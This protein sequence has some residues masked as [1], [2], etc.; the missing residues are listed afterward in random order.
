MKKPFRAYSGDQPYIF[1]SYAHE[2]SSAVYP[3]MKWLQDQGFN[4]WY[5]EGISPGTVWRT[6]LADSIMGAGLF[7]FFVTPRSVISSNCEKEVNFAI[8]HDIPVL[9]VHLEETVLPSGMELTLSSIQGIL[10]FDLSEQDYREKLL[11]STSKHL[12]RGIGSA[13]A[14]SSNQNRKIAIAISAVLG[15]LL[16]GYLAI[17][18][19]PSD[20]P[21]NALREASSLRRFTI[22]LPRSMQL[23]NILFR[24]VIIS[25]DGQRVIFS[26]AEKREAQLYSR[27]LD[28]LDVVPIK[29]TENASRVLALSPDN[30]WIAF[31]DRSTSMLIKVPVTG[32]IPIPLC[33]LDGNVWGLSWGAND[34]IL[35]TSGTSDGLMQVS[36]SGGTPEQLTF[37]ENGEVHKQAAFL[38]DASA[39]FFTIGEKGSTIRKADRIAVLSLE[40]GEQKTLMAGASPQATPNGHLIYYVNNALWAV[41]FDAD[42]LEVKGQSVPVADGVLYADS[43]HYSMSD[44][45]T[46]VYVLD[47]GLEKRSLV[48]V[49]RFGNEEVIPIDPRHYLTA[50]ISP[51]GDR[52]A[53]T[54]KTENGFDL[55]MY[56][57][58]RGTSRQLTFDESYESGMAWSPD[59]QYIYYSSNRI[60]NI[61]RVSTDGLAVIERLTNSAE[62][63]FVDSITPDGRQVIFTTYD[64]VTRYQH[65][66]NILTMSSEPTSE[67]LIKTGFED[68]DGA[69]SPNGLWLAYT[70]NRSGRDEV[71]VSPFPDVD[72][73]NWQV[74]VGGGSAPRWG[75][76][77]QE[78]FYL[79]PTNVMAVSIDTAPEFEAGQP[80]SLFRHQDYN[81]SFRTFGV[82]PTGERFLLVKKPTEDVMSTNRIVIVQNWL[83][84]VARKF[85]T[86]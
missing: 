57:L 83:D 1:V 73:G 6:E 84:D 46:L 31:V 64:N 58:T 4:V 61:F 8:D 68:D 56:S 35:F 86:N 70:S 23:S 18:Y 33:D 48:W 55:W 22:D 81:I 28:S 21:L 71:Y 54:V 69:L 72:A 74:S 5:D 47:S 13:P 19:L 67:V 16:A 79:G 75:K 45:G 66:I 3:E 36:S 2:D 38:L 80:E 7:L 25:A 11:A 77:G 62:R 78:L 53:A 10:K 85:A 27:S 82:D 40:S 60:D 12:Q 9:T 15:L 26:A 76:N 44:D 37:P 32:G 17:N 42:R 24:P 50:H 39:V 30:Q 49:D 34:K 51:G 41:A 43:A 14:V 59:G 20:T 52:I 63:Q 29:G 65:S